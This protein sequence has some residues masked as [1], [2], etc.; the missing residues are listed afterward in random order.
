VTRKAARERVLAVLDVARRI[1][2]ARDDLGIA[3][4]A[5]LAGTSGL[6]PQG[7]ELA[8]SR[9]LE[10]SATEEEL[11]RLLA[12]VSEAPRC[13]VVLA[14]NVCTAAVRAVALAAATARSIA[15]RPSRR[16]PGLAP[17]LVGELA[18]SGRFQEA[19]GSVSL[20]RSI[21][22]AP[23]DEVHAYG[24]DA[25]I[26]QIRGGLPAGVVFRG[27]GTGFGAAYVAPA[28]DLDV[29]ARAL[30]ED[31][32]A[33]DQRGCLSPRLAVV[34]G[35]VG[36]GG[37]FSVALSAALHEAAARVPRGPL[38][39][40]VAAEAGAFRALAESLGDVFA[41]DDHLVAFFGAAPPL[42]LPPPARF[43]SVACAGD[44]GACAQLLEPY[45]SFLTTIGGAT[46]HDAAHPLAALTSVRFSELGKM[47]R[48]PLDGP[49]DR[50]GSKR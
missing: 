2:D 6:S 3:A 39:E 41:D 27:H 18:S 28:A 35:D 1:A 7:I 32:V 13:H 46:V 5:E 21:A 23:R 47:Q 44:E 30:A 16:D 48:P 34:C 33:F 50:R 45:R 42:P 15:V 14:A 43:V 49:V 36:R 19:D 9:H 4:R 10:T 12:G 8:L 25:S 24:S 11:D 31:V 26:E 38:D 29:A 20:V 22:P 37:A 40:G 17:L